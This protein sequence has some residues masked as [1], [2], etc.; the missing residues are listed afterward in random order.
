MNRQQPTMISKDRLYDSD[1][2]EFVTDAS[3]LGF[4]PGQWPNMISPDKPIGNGQDFILVQVTSDA[5]FYQ[6]DLGCYRIVVFND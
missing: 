5:A 2:N 3:E 1:W 6:Q 4:P